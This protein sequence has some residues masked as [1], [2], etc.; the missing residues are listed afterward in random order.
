MLGVEATEQMC[1]AGSRHFLHFEQFP[2]CA[3]EYVTLQF[4]SQVADDHL[5]GSLSTFIFYERLVFWIYVDLSFLSG[6]E[7]ICIHDYF[8]G[9]SFLIIS[10]FK[11]I[12]LI[13][14]SPTDIKIV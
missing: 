12:S 9:I 14:T 5:L 6:L 2:G 11:R 8:L 1:R 3:L 7:S 4:L 10:Y 13:F